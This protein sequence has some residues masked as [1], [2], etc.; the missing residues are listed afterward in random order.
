MFDQTEN[1]LLVRIHQNNFGADDKR[2]IRLCNADFI[3]IHLPQTIPI[4]KIYC[5]I[6]ATATT[7]ETQNPQ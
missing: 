3:G 1:I 4:L 2:I 5:K 7:T 6:V